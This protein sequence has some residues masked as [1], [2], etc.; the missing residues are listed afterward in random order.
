M[1]NEGLKMIKRTMSEQ[2][3]QNMNLR[4]TISL[5]ACRLMNGTAGGLPK[6]TMDCSKQ[7]TYM[8]IVDA[9]MTY[10]DSQFNIIR[11]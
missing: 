9:W 11:D 4:S 5:A 6:R 2:G 10:Y 1:M 7:S 3:I 8:S